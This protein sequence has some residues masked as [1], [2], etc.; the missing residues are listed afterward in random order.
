ML[1]QFAMIHMGL[2]IPLWIFTIHALLDA[3]LVR[4]VIEQVLP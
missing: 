3:A 2:P 1:D 4:R